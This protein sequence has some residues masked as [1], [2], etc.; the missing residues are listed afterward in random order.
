MLLELLEGIREYFVLTCAADI[1]RVYAMTFLVPTIMWVYFST[2]KR[3]FWD[4]TTL[5]LT[6]YQKATDRLFTVSSARAT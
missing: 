2:E 5:N 6:E 1:I 4:Y 3:I